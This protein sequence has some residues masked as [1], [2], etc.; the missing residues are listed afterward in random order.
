[1]LEC[2]SE[3]VGA[4][5]AILFYCNATVCVLVSVVG[6]LGWQLATYCRKLILKINVIIFPVHLGMP[7]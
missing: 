1:M 4:G 5:L 3:Y 2:Y 7:Y 6:S